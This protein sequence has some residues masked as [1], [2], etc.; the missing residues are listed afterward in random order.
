MRPDVHSRDHSISE[1]KARFSP[2]YRARIPRHGLGLLPP[3]FHQG[4]WQ[5]LRN[6]N[7]A[8]LPKAF[9]ERLWIVKAVLHDI[10]CRETPYKPE[11][12]WVQQWSETSLNNASA[13]RLMAPCLVL[14]SLTRS[15]DRGLRPTWPYRPSAGTSWIGDG[16]SHD[17]YVS[18]EGFKS[19]SVFLDNG[20]RHMTGFAFID[21]S[22][23]TRFALVGTGDDHALGSIFQVG[24]CL[25]GSS[26][27]WWRP[28]E[29]H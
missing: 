28:L 21:I 2:G 27:H 23:E 19:L 26:F 6:N 29:R 24:W 14:E 4:G 16:H 17:L 25:G 8:I 15:L 9:P 11:M 7:K 10:C 18:C 22:H 12:P 1:F 13:N 20:D 5:C 3:A